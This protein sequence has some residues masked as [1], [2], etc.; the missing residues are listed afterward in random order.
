MR[1]IIEDSDVK[2]AAAS[3][4]AGVSSFSTPSST[5]NSIDAGPP[6]AS[7]MQAASMDSNANASD[8]GG[9]PET[10]LQ[11]IQGQKSMNDSGSSFQVTDAGGA[12]T[13]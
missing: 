12:P 9:P 3:A 8:A 5:I 10:L 4:T 13:A 2:A 7:L 11:A 6:A 1:I